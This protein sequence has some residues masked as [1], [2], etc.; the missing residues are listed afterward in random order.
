MFLMDHVTR[1]APKRRAV[2]FP[3]IVTDA[4]TLGVTRQH[5]YGVLVGSRQSRRLL[6]AYR[7]LK[8]EAS[9]P[10]TTH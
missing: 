2:K 1:R 7:A 10:S 8:G 3:G 9:K 6:N 4:E 5:L